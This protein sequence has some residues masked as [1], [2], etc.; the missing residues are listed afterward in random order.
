MKY[1]G[2]YNNSII[3]NLLNKNSPVSIPNREKTYQ[4]SKSFQ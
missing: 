1:K 4:K 3:L 2:H